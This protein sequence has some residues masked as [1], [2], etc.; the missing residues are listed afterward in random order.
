MNQPTSRIMHTS[1][2]HDT[3]ALIEQLSARITPVRRLPSPLWR[4]LTWL[5]LAAAVITAVT[6]TYGLRQGLWE[7]MSAG[8][9]AVEWVASVVTGALAAYAVFQV[10]VPGRS[11]SWAWL[12]VPVMLLWLGGLGWGCIE[13]FMRM[14][15]GALV[16]QAGSWDCAGAITF[17]SVP[18]GLVMLLMVRHAGVVRPAT[19]AML[20]ALS[21]ASLSAAG[22]SLFHPG[23]N[24]LMVLVWHLGAVVV[25]SL[26]CWAFGRRLFAW[27]GHAR[28]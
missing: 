19:T 25:V 26:L 14:G 13:D 4:T 28:R 10:S 6:A 27:L 12:P 1:T 20:A 23:E 2:R 5:I 24:A 8:P 18:M 22:V 7:A 11:A 17:I 16:Y 15:S 9:M 21:A 3:T